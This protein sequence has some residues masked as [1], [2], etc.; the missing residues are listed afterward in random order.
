MPKSATTWVYRQLI[1]NPE[2][3]YSG[4]K[5]PHFDV[6]YNFDSYKDY[7]NQFEFS[8]NMNVELWSIDSDL[9]S[10]LSTYATHS[11]I[12]FRNPYEFVNS[13]VNYFEPNCSNDDYINF[14]IE[15]AYLEYAR[16]IQRLKTY[17]PTLQVFVQDQ[18]ANDP[19]GTMDRLTDY[20]SICS[21]PVDTTKV[22]VTEYVGNVMFTKDN[23]L[24]INKSIDEFVDYSGIDVK[25]WKR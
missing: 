25:H 7:N 1:A 5:E 22:N 19:Q 3:D 15:A 4:V 21:A 12:I 16:N 10:T 23:I 20:L 6:L 2:V 17:F 8:L 11:S 18:I 14:V 24:T 13:A 9:L